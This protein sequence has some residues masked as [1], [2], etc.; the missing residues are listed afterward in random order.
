MIRTL[1][2]LSITFLSLFPAA[3]QKNGSSKFPPA[4]KV[5]NVHQIIERFYVDSIDAEKVATEAI[6]AMLRNLDPHS[7]YSDPKETRELNEPL[8]GTFSGIGI[9]FNMLDDTVKVIQTVAGGPSEKVG[10][11]A[12]D[13]I[14]SANDTLISG[15]KMPQSQV[16]GHLRGPKGSVVQIKVRRRG[17]ADTIAFNITRDDIPTYSV[18][19]AY[20]VDDSIG[21]I[22]VTL[23]G[24]TTP[25]EVRKAAANL[26]KKGMRHLILDL[27]DNGGGYLGAAIDL[28]GMFLA[29]DELIVYTE[30]LHSPAVQYTNTASP[31]PGIER[32]VVTVNQFS[33]SASEILAGAIQDQDRGFI[34]GRRT[35]GKGLVQRPFPF[36]DGS[37]VRLTT[38]R[39]HTPSGRC[40]QKPYNAGEEDAYNAEVVHRYLSGELSSS[41]SIHLNDS[42]LY[43]TLKLN[44]PVYGGGGINPDIFVPIDTAYYSTYWRDILA[45]GILHRYTNNYIDSLR[46]SL[47]KLYRTEDRFIDVFTVTPDMIDGLTTLAAAN[48]VPLDSAGLATSLPAF[49]IY[50]KAL[51]G[52]DLFEQSTYYRVANSI[53]PV[54]SEAVETIRRSRGPQEAIRPSRAKISE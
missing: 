39:Y 46:P 52:H 42:L 30:G 34:V 15:V 1:I 7:S 16:M 48:G 26:A 51:I 54:F 50:V 13:R 14:L 43:H 35:F 12:G 31:L 10:V 36:P 49:R 17:E 29:P 22:K 19:S 20:M 45:K 32:L 47:K 27:E 11:L 23:F 33:A 28:A 18:S 24:L 44:R 21:Y 40:I 37:M 53:N 8:Q 38:A 4:A 41:D 2:F 6:V 3:A 5:A 25:D 9:Q